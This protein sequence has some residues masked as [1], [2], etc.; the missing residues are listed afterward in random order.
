MAILFRN[1]KVII[2]TGEVI[3]KGTVAINTNLITYVGITKKIQPSKKD[4]VFDISGRTILPGL[5]DCHV[6]LCLDGSADPLQ[7]LRGDS[8]QMATLK[9][10]RNA[11]LSLLA[12]VTTV[13]DLGSLAGITVS[14]RDAS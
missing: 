9:A 11:Y 2:G 6:H 4:T 10:A 8:M 3:E 5:I 7:S 14:L 1:G 13:R 12:G